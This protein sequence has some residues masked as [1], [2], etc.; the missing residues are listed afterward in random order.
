M[1]HQIID[2]GI[3]ANLLERVE[4]DRT[5]LDGGLQLY[6]ASIDGRDVHVT[7]GGGDDA[8]LIC[9]ADDARHIHNAIAQPRPYLRLV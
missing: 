6:T 5:D 2:I 4:F 8:V 7:C 1:H 9:H 3:L